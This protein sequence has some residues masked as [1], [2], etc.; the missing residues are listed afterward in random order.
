M[1]PHKGEDSK[2]RTAFGEVDT[3]E[4]IGRIPTIE[5]GTYMAEDIGD[6]GKAQWLP[7]TNT[8]ITLAFVTPISQIADYW[9]R[10]GPLVIASVVTCVG[11]I[12]VSRA[13][14]MSTAIAGNVF[15]STANAVSPLVFA[16]AAEI[17][18]RRYRSLAQGGMTGMQ[19]TAGIVALLGGTSLCKN[20]VE[21]WRILWYL[22]AGVGALTAVITFLCYNP[23][24]RELQ[25]ALSL[26]EKLRCLDW[27]GICAVPIGLTLVV[28]GLTWSQNPYGWNDAHI[29]APFILGMAILVF[30]IFYEVKIKKDGLFH[31]ELF[32]KSR[33]FPLA[34]I[35]I[36]VEGSVFFTAN[37]FF[38]TE[39]GILF[40]T[41]PLQIGLRFSM[42][43]FTAF[44]ASFIVGWYISWQKALRGAMILGFMCFTAFY[45]AMIGVNEGS[46][47]EMWGL[48]VILGWGLGTVLT[49]LVTAAQFGTPPELIS[50]S[51]GAL[52][53]VRTFGASISLPINN[54]IF[55]S[56]IQKHLGPGITAAV[57]PLGLSPDVLGRFI[58]ALSANNKAALARIPGVTPEIIQAGV[59]ALQAAYVSSFRIMWIMPLVLSVL[60]LSSCLFL[61]NPREEF[62]MH[63]D[64]PVES[65]S[66]GENDLKTAE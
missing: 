63:V 37:T 50:L 22:I 47:K 44:V 42:T 39:V 48:A 64:A 18:P 8:I 30:I 61:A 40:T 49:S 12:I 35:Q 1:A 36:F 28:V 16:V 31:H 23:P 55:N 27:V 21:G 29:M 32:R 52:L 14:N 41:D 62:T 9:G 2:E 26:N 11:S 24:P 54:A 66:S 60:A 34:L 57:L 59:H 38:T 20:Y 15:A 13:T 51:A 46:S 58:E 45:G 4:D 53:C 33:N 6:P 17:V 10:K 19:S 7:Q 5:V 43:F 25:T 3:V 56:Q 65:E